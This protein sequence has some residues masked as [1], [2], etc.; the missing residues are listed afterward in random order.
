MLHWARERIA[1]DPLPREPA[2]YGAMYARYL[3]DTE[4]WAEAGD[5]LAPDG[6]DVPTPHYAFARAYAAARLGKL[7]E[8]RVLL[9]E[10]RPGGEAANPEIILSAKEIDILKLQVESVIAMGEGNAER[11]ISL[12]RQAAEMQ[13]SM[14]FRYGP[15]R[16]SKPASE[17]LAD[18]LFE[19][20]RYKEAYEYYADQL[21]RSQLRTNSLIGL[22]RASLKTG[23]ET[24]AQEA[25]D[26]LSKIWR[27]ADQDLP[28]HIE[29]AKFEGQ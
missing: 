15:P 19:L 28:M 1:D 6:V 21:S 10:I 13:A 3:I 23:D 7:E 26:S 22:A 8:A 11:A 24:A 4:L 17:L 27:G 29:A 12:A 20:G 5:W 18:L 9:V 16:I 25:Y 14:P 2:Y